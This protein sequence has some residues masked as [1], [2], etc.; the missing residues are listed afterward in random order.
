LND[1]KKANVFLKSLEQNEGRKSEGLTDK[2]LV[3]LK[4]L[5]VAPYHNKTALNVLIDEIKL[6][7]YEERSLST[8]FEWSKE[9]RGK[10]QA[11]LIYEKIIAYPAKSAEEIQIVD[12][13]EEGRFSKSGDMFLAVANLSQGSRRSEAAYKAGV[14]YARAGLFDKAKSAWLLAANDTSDKRYSSL[15]SERLDRINK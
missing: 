7:R 5:S 6:G 13:R 3:A 14:V 8:L 1:S 15:A 11:E 9:L 4:E 2:S 12:L 10:P